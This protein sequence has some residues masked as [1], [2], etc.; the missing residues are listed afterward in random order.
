MAMGIHTQE[1][2]LGLFAGIYR[3]NNNVSVV[4]TCSQPAFSS[5]CLRCWLGTG[6]PSTHSDI[7]IEVSFQENRKQ[8]TK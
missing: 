7:Y 4:I 2:A 8:N 5:G 6:L 3:D 1:G